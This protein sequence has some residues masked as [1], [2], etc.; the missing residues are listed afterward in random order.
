V[1]ACLQRCSDSDEC[2]LVRF[3]LNADGS[4]DK[5]WLRKGQVPIGNSLRTLVRTRLSDEDVL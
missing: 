1:T 2:A 3:S 5:C 4:I